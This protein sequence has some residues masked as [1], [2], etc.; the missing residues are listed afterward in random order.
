ML[1]Q[2]FLD[3][4]IERTGRADLRFPPEA[5]S[6]FAAYDWPGNVRELENVVERM[7]VLSRTDVLS[8]VTMPDALREGG[9][10]RGPGFRLPPGGVRLGELEKDLIRQ[11]LE[12][13]GGNRT[14]SA[15]LLGLTRSALL[16][17][18]QKFGLE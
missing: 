8:P 13:T 7:V 16:Y 10:D 15:A 1:A 5:L 9:A 11:A 2:H 3:R 6:R 17:R 12:R 4:W 14:R 18:M